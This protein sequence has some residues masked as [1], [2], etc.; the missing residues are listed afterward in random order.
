MV[1]WMS[2]RS[3]LTA[4]ESNCNRFRGFE[5]LPHRIFLN[6]KDLK[7]YSINI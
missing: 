2:G 6:E 1:G 3:Q 4:N 5:S 7:I